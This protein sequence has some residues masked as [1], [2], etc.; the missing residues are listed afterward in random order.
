MSLIERTSYRCR[1]SVP[2][3]TIW[4]RSGTPVPWNDG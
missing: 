3:W 1:S 4:R 2:S